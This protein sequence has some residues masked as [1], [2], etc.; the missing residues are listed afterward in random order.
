[1]C[2]LRFPSYWF[3]SWLWITHWFAGVNVWE[4]WTV[5]QAPLTRETHTPNSV[6]PVV[7][8][9][10]LLS[11]ISFWLPVIFHL[12]PWNLPGAYADFRVSA[13]LTAWLAAQLLIQI[14]PLMSQTWSLTS[15]TWELVGVFGSRAHVCIKFHFTQDA[16]LPSKVRFSPVSPA[17]GCFP[18]PSNCF[19]NK[20]LTGI[21]SV[22]YESM[23]QILS[24]DSHNDSFF[25]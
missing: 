18:V 1:M 14:P 4:V 20:I 12:A 23:S 11:V 8:R 5:Y 19:L 21:Y 25:F 2:H 3:F 7:S 16:L 24:T 10:W 15:A 22:V 6:F 17:F 13:V 9:N